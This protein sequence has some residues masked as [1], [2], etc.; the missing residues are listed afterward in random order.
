MSIA[1][2]TSSSWRAPV[3]VR[4]GFGS[5]EA[6]RS[7]TEAVDYLTSRWPHVESDHHRVALHK[8]RIASSGAIPGEVAREA[9]ISAAIEAYV[10]A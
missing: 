2:M 4:I 8:C 5:S 10:L 7:P 9:F 6:V 1:C 3:L